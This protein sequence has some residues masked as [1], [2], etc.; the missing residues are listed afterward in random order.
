MFTLKVTV[1]NAAPRAPAA[2]VMLPPL[3]IYKYTAII[4][5]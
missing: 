3:N 4:I 2:P 5:T 1:F